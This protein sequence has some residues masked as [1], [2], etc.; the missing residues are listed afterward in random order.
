MKCPICGHV[1]FWYTL[2]LIEFEAFKVR[3]ISVIGK[4][5]WVHVVFSAIFT[6]ADKFYDFLFA[7]LIIT[8]TG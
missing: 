8:E 5:K 6:K 7:F 2:L 4:G 1:L 3:I